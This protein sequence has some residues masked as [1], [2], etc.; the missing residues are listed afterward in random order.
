MV[1]LEYIS[2]DN[3]NKMLLYPN[4]LICVICLFIIISFHIALT[5]R[6]SACK[7]KI[8][9]FG[10]NLALYNKTLNAANDLV[11]KITNETN[12]KKNKHL[13][14]YAA[15]SSKVDAHFNDIKQ[16]AKEIDEDKEEN[17]KFKAGEYNAEL[18]RQKTQLND[19]NYR[20]STLQ[21]LKNAVNEKGIKKLDI[22]SF[23][24]NNNEIYGTGGNMLH[25]KNLDA[26]IGDNID[27]GGINKITLNAGTNSIS[28]G[29]DGI[30]T[31]G[32][33]VINGSTIM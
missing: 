21:T 10:K 28:F 15:C 25:F 13:H 24:I 12:N 29:K 14:S 16:Y 26:N 33:L 9:T 30:N 20:F 3:N 32:A 1:H 23:S 8:K 22:N 19:L 4:I 2:V 5:Q 27:M 18:D 31:K 6:I 17:F 7:T 11:F